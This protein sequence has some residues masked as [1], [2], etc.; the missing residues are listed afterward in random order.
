[1]PSDRY[2]SI[3]KQGGRIAAE[4]F[5]PDKQYISTSVSGPGAGK[6]HIFLRIK[7]TLLR[8]E[9][10][11]NSEF[12]IWRDRDCYNIRYMGKIILENVVIEPVAGHCPNNLYITVGESCILGCH[13]C[14]I[15][16]GTESIKS[17]DRLVSIT[18]KYINDIHSVGLTSGFLGNHKEIDT[19]ISYIEWFKK[20]HNIPVGVSV[21][22]YSFSDIADI[23]KAGADE[24]KLNIEFYERELFEKICPGKDYD[25]I[26][27]LLD[28][29]VRVF[30]KNRVSSNLIVGAGEHIDTIKKCL[31]D[32]AKKGII[33]NLREFKY[34]QRL[35]QKIENITGREII[36]LDYKTKIDIALF[37]K[38]IEKKYKLN[39]K[40][41]RTLCAGCGACDIL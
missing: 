36:P 7:N 11:N 21:Y 14:E 24:F 34:S 17:F 13:F 39:S 3:L 22:P 23:K 15:K 10:D 26:L 6:K 5:Y 12:S 9:I 18:E 29:S 20:H 33:V 28:E 16:S 31:E 25:F 41:L 4:N 19:I 2:I 30:G 32:F 27:E 37:K 38:N 35:K 8:L 40:Q 1:M